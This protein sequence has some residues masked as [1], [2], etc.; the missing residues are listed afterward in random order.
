M[1]DELR[2]VEERWAQIV[3]ERDVAAAESFLADDFVLQ[4]AGGVSPNALKS[5]WLETLPQIETRSIE[6]SDVE[7]RVFGDVA[8]VRLRLAWEAELAGRDLTGDYAIVDVFTRG[9]D[10]WQPRWRISTRLTG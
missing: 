6:A 1:S 2:A 8:V 9:R 5:D 7:T 10:G 3:R 4:S